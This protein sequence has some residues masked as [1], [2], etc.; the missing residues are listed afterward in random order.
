MHFLFKSHAVREPC[1]ALFECKEKQACAPGRPKPTGFHA[2]LLTLML[3]RAPF[4][5]TCIPKMF[6]NGQHA[7][8]TD[9][10]WDVP[11]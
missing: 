4:C 1:N 3:K 10:T 7:E 2:T 11:H 8:P 6:A 5:T 9:L